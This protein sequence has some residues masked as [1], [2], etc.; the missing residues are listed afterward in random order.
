MKRLIRIVS[1]CGVIMISSCKSSKTGTDSSLSVAQDLND[2]TITVKMIIT[3]VPAE[4]QIISI[5][6]EMPNLTEIVETS[7]GS[8]FFIDYNNI[9][10]SFHLVT[11][12]MIET[13]QERLQRLPYVKDIFIE[14][15]K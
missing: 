10:I 1:F 5:A 4:T 9:K 8:Y 13:I 3:D 14:K 7:G 12:R 6:Q 2:Y 11:Q 15:N